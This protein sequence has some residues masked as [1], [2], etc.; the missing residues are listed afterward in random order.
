MI[1]YSLFRTMITPRDLLHDD[2]VL[3]EHHKN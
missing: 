3:K 2:Q 1:I